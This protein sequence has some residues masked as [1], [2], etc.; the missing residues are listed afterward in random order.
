[1]PGYR[2][3]LVWSALALVAAPLAARVPGLAK[4]GIRYG[5]HCEVSPVVWQGRLL[6][7]VSVRPID[8]PAERVWLELQDGRDGKVIST[9]GRGY[10]LASAFAWQGTLYVYAARLDREGW[11]D[12]TE[13]RS[14][15]LVTWSPARVVIT[16]NADE[17]L[18]NTSVCRAGDRFLMAYESNDPRWPAFT[19]KFACSRDLESWRPLP[20]ALF[21]TDRYA[22]CPCL[23][24]L[25]GWHYLLYLEHRTPA[26]RFETFLARSRDLVSWEP[27]PCNPI[28][29]PGPGE[30]ANTSDPDLAELGGRTLLYYSYGDQ[31]TW[32]ELTRAEYPGPLRDFIAACYPG[33]PA[34]P[35]LLRP[36]SHH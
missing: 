7:L 21:G 20:G 29:T 36:Q 30:N 17:Q 23:R 3:L 13:F 27:S 15:D 8:A 33:G 11:R 32:S 12:V 34:R 19:I 35:R 5:P 22:A 26:W 4:T 18:F 2:Q 24:Y 10:S 31:R 28:L 6:H 16:G 9:L 25:D 14:R 1:M